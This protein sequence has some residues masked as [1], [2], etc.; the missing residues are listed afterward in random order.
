FRIVDYAMQ[1][2]TG[3]LLRSFWLGFLT[4]ASNPKTAVVYASIFVSL[5]PDGA[6]PTV[7]FLLPAAIFV[8]E[9]GWFSMGALALS[10]SSPRAVYLRARPWIDRAAGGVMMLLGSK[11]LW[12]TRG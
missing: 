12:E 11:L 6:S 1:R 10:A 3:T 4:Q 8:V 9:A 2:H 7:A 5:L